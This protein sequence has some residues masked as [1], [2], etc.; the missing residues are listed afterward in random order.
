MT[1][2][3]RKSKLTFCQLDSSFLEVFFLCSAPV[4]TT[5]K[6]TQNQGDQMSFVKKMKMASK[7]AQN[8]PKPYIVGQVY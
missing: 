2:A 1:E 7:I 6:E 4:S 3:K 5:C 8:N